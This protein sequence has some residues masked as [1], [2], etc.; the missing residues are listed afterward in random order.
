MDY[1]TIASEIAF[2]GK[3]FRVRVDNVRNPSGQKS[4]VDVV[5]H[6]GAVVM[7]P[8]EKDNL[9]WLVRQYRH[10]TGSYILELPAGTLDP[11]EEPAQCAIRECRE[12]IGMAPGKLEELGGF[13]LAPGYSTEFI[14]AFLAKDLQ[15]ASLPRDEDEDLH[16]ERYSLEELERL[17]QAKEIKDAKTI[18]AL[19]LARSHLA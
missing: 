19:S 12:E 17:I 11:S 2:E 18:A 16:I 4:R 15:P 10:P 7:V 14:H 5:E 6:A 3:V 1:E 13:Y 8:I 9:I